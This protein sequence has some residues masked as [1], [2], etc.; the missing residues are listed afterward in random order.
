[1]SCPPDSMGTGA[2]SS[3]SSCLLTSCFTLGGISIK[4]QHYKFTFAKCHEHL[5]H[6]SVSVPLATTFSLQFVPWTVVATNMSRLE[7]RH[8]TFNIPEP[9]ILNKTVV[10]ELD[11]TL[12]TLDGQL[13]ESTS[14]VNADISTIHT[15]TS[16]SS[17]DYVAYIALSFSLTSCTTW[18]IVFYLYRRYGLQRSVQ[19]NTCHCGKLRATTGHVNEVS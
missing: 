11:K 12:A 14:A 2:D 3:N 5:D 19:Q 7:L 9:M 15:G 8:P 1:M 10:A 16:L 18:P 4:K 13:T 6:I 17:S